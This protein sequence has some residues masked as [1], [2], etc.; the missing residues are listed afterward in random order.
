MGITVAVFTLILGLSSILLEYTSSNKL[1]T[2]A[3]ESTAGVAAERVQQEIIAYENIAVSYGARSD[4]ADPEIP[5]SEKE[6][7]LTQ[8]VESYGMIR[9]NLIDA[10]GNSYFDGNSYADRDYFQKCMAGETYIST[11]VLS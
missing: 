11:P 10:A 4:I 9:A 1:L 6:T 2:Q 8:A 7:I 5:V 3:M